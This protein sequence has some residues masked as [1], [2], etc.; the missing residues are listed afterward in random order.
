LGGLNEGYQYGQ[1][2]RGK[3]SSRLQVKVRLLPV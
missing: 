3:V 1:V 2:S